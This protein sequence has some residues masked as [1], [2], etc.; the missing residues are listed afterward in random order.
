GVA[1]RAAEQQCSGVPP[2]GETR[3]RT[4]ELVIQVVDTIPIDQVVATAQKF[5][6][7]LISTQHLDQTPR[8]VFRFR[9]TGP[10]D[11]RK[12]I[13]MWEKLSIVASVQ[14]NYNFVT[15]QTA[16]AADAPP[17]STRQ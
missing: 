9:A 17:A 11:L 14:P 10:A 2:P 15:A 6:F 13:P 3:F 16:P 1:R 8:N 7:V 5:G 12:L 4:G